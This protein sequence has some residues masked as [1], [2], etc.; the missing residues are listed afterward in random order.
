MQAQEPRFVRVQKVEQ[1]SCKKVLFEIE[2]LSEVVE[3][4]TAIIGT[5][6]SR[7]SMCDRLD[8]LVFQP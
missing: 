7:V 3:S 8:K 5:V 6:H 1:A 4:Q 2:I